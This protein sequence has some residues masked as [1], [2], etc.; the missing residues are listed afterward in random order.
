[1][2]L[3]M[4]FFWLNE[5]LFVCSSSRLRPFGRKASLGK[6]PQNC[7]R[8]CGD[9]IVVKHHIGQS[10]VSYARILPF[11]LDDC[12]PFQWQQ[13]MPLWRRSRNA[14]PFPASGLPAKVCCSGYAEYL[15][16]MLYLKTRKIFKSFYSCHQL[17]CY[18]GRNLAAFEPA[19]FA[20]FNW[21]TSVESSE[22]TA[23][24][25]MILVSFSL[26]SRSFSRVKRA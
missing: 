17:L 8:R 11:V 19:P 20:F 14:F 24:R 10:S 23:L 25:L 9:N 22:T 4:G 16:R 13:V 18:L 26:S 5:T 6:H 21:R 1:M 2:P 7:G 3:F 12:G 15:Q